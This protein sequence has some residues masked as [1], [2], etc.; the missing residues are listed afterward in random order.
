MISFNI[1]IQLTC[2][3]NYNNYFCYFQLFS[4]VISVFIFWFCLFVFI[5]KGSKLCGFVDRTASLF[6][7]KVIHLTM[8]VITS[9]QFEF[10]VHISFPS[11]LILL[12]LIASRCVIIELYMWSKRRHALHQDVISY[13]IWMWSN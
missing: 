10:K 6:E 12:T 8:S 1:F 7:F 4:W 9:S 2:R 13:S 5:F 11:I 3:I